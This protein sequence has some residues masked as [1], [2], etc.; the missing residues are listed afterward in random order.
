[1]EWTESIVKRVYNI[2]DDNN[3]ECN[4][5]LLRMKLSM[6]LKSN[7]VL[8]DNERV[9][10]TC[11]T[12]GA[13]HGHG[14]CMQR[15]GWIQRLQWMYSC[16]SRA[17]PH[18]SNVDTDKPVLKNRHSELRTRKRAKE[19]EYWIVPPV[20]R[21]RNGGGV[22]RLHIYTYVFL[23]EWVND[24]KNARNGL[25][26]DSEDGLRY[27]FWNVTAQRG[28]GRGATSAR[29]SRWWMSYPRVSWPTPSLSYLLT[30]L[31]T[32]LLP[33]VRWYFKRLSDM[34]WGHIADSSR[35]SLSSGDVWRRKV[36]DSWTKYSQHF[37]ELFE[38]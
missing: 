1:M 19:G 23:R 20:H 37:L 8:F 25:P 30:Y 36:Y 13:Q 10:L 35:S 4:D 5:A 16:I 26:V 9:R 34:A 3:G 28:A 33:V 22:M 32:H 15:W 14:R 18:H 7:V 11:S 31:F 29:I 6:T 17:C 24:R 2:D 21:T 27:L 38:S 12:P